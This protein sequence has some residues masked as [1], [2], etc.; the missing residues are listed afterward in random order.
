MTAMCDGDPQSRVLQLADGRSVGIAEYGA[1]DGH[2]VLALHGAPA[3]RLMY[4][5]ADDAARRAGLRLFAPDRP[6]YGLT[7]PD[8]NPTLASRTEWLVRIADA[9]GLDRFALLAI[10]GGGPYATALASRLGNRVTALA[11]VS[12]MGPVADDMASP[13]ASLTLLTFLQRHFFLALPRRWFFPALGRAAVWVYTASNRGGLAN[14]P[15]LIGDPDAGILDKPGVREV[16]VAMTREALRNGAAGAIADLQIY[17][18]PWQVDYSGITAPAILWLGL[19]DR[20]VP[21]AAALHL[22]ECIPGCR[23]V[24]FEQAGHF[25]VFGQLD[26]LCAALHGAIETGH[27]NG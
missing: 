16:M 25:F 9:L 12:P 10:S 26:S 13:A 5:I 15:R 21:V 8:D 14:L 1:P 17:S 18:R 4:A 27:S 6:G 7:P 19:A 3:C 22:A 23:L 11:L 24:R 2:P 20:I